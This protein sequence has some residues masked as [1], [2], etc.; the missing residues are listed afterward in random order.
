MP[1]A[2]PWDGD[3]TRS[4]SPA[5]SGWGRTAGAPIELGWRNLAAGED[6]LRM[7]ALRRQA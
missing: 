5:I 1:H 7:E 6:E 3:A 2:A 4:S